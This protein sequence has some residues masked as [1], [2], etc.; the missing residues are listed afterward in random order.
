MRKLAK[1]DTA[2]SVPMETRGDELGEMARAVGHFKLG[3]VERLDLEAKAQQAA[4]RREATL[5]AIHARLSGQRIEGSA[6]ALAE[7]ARAGGVGV[8]PGWEF[9]AP[10]AGAE[11]SVFDLAG[12]AAV[13]VDEPTDVQAELDKWWDRVLALHE[14]SLVGNLARPE[15]IVWSP[16]EL[17][18]RMEMQGGVVAPE[19]STA[20]G[21]GKIVSVLIWRKR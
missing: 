11:H 17:D 5:A 14:R 6:E 7:T 4:A 9:Y 8:F 19:L 15:E 2:V 20:S 18:R 1:D 3:I 16:E 13:L 12:N 10:L 21:T